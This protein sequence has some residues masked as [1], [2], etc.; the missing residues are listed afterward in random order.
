MLNLKPVFMKPILFNILLCL[1]CLTAKAQTA[2]PVLSAENHATIDSV[3]VLYSPVSTGT[4][5][6]SAVNVKAEITIK[7]KAGNT[8]KIFLQ[9]LNPAD[10]S[11]AYAVD[12]ALTAAPYSNQGKVTFSGQDL[13][14]L[15]L[16][17]LTLPLS[18]FVYK[19][20]TRSAQGLNS[21]VFVTRQ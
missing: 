17:P 1:A 7:L 8:E 2:M 5:N 15:I 20:H 11:V 10:S 4:L 14:F 16:C 13:K 21:A 6:A 3:V 19:V 9:M 12:Y 18:T